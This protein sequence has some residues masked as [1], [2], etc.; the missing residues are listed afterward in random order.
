MTAPDAVIPR[1]RPNLRFSCSCRSGMVLRITESVEGSSSGG[2]YSGPRP[3]PPSSLSSEITDKWY[4]QGTLLEVR[5]NK[6]VVAFDEVDWWPL[7]DPG[8]SYQCV[9]V[10][11]LLACFIP[12]R[13]RL[14]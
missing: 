6:L 13:S 14:R 7:D 12:N 9:V 1:S 4:V 2:D 11:V 8:E 5:R 10:V 3:P